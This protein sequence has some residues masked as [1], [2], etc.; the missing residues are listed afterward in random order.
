MTQPLLSYSFLNIY[1]EYNKYTHDDSVGSRKEVYREGISRVYIERVYR[2]C[3]SRGYI[4][5]VYRECIS[6][7]YI[8]RIYRECISRG[9]IDR[10]LYYTL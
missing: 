10:W 2:E 3:I 4:E 8:E 9:Y 6:R 7:G 5:S 1:I